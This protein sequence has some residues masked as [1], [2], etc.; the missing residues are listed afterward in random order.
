MLEFR[1]GLRM[2][3]ANHEP[4]GHEQEIDE[5]WGHGQTVYCNRCNQD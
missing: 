2:M 5:S 4:I 1:S 3:G